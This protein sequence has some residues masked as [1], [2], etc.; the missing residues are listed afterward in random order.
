ML[1]LHLTH[2]LLFFIDLVLVALNVV[3][4]VAALHNLQVL[5]LCLLDKQLETELRRH[6]FVL[7][8]L[9]QVSSHARRRRRVLPRWT[10]YVLLR[11]G[12]AS[13]SWP[14]ANQVGRDGVSELLAHAFTARRHHLN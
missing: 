4:C 13:L 7:P 8:R 3:K 10:R 2:G 14:L 6:L 12:G 1:R 11:D 5:L 9:T